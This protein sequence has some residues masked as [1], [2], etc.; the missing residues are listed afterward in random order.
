MKKDTYSI[1]LIKELDKNGKKFSAFVVCSNADRKLL[2][3]KNEEISLLNMTIIYSLFGHDISSKVASDVKEYIINK[4]DN[5]ID[6]SGL[7][8]MIETSEI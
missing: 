7:D 2:A 5:E 8:A 3:S 6:L 1:E 4:I